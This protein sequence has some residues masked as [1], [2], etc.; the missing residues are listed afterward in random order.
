MTSRPEIILFPFKLLAARAIVYNNLP[1]VSLATLRFS[2]RS[3][4]YI[5]AFEKRD[6][7]IV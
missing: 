6:D 7:L 1:I 3:F 5:Y 2:G 4:I